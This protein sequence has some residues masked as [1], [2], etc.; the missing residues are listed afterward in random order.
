[1]R[2]HHRPRAEAV[3]DVLAGY[4]QVAL[5]LL[6]AKQIELAETYLQ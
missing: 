6:D 1:M 5:P 4:R 3:A 2:P